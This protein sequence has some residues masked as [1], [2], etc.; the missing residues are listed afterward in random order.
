MAAASPLGLPPATSAVLSQRSVRAYLTGRSPALFAM[1]V[2][3]AKL[4]LLGHF[5]YI[6]FG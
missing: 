6:N 3:D 1:I 5:L 2:R 4:Y